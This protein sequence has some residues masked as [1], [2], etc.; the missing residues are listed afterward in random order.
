MGA[1]LIIVS[2]YIYLI[3]KQKRKLRESA[4]AENK[5]QEKQLFFEVK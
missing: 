2:R 4:G 3:I 5:S 1:S